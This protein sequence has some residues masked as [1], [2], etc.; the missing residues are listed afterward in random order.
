MVFITR[1]PTHLNDGSPV[2][3]T[4][5][6]AVLKRVWTTF[7]GYTLEGP[8]EGAWVDDS[9]KLYSETS[10][11]LEVFCDRERLHEAKALVIEIGRELGQLA[12]YFEVRHCDGVE[13]ID[14][15]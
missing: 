2:T 13:L 11:R 12:M 14:C 8:A 7:G 3:K 1:I 9:G 15:R 10:Y 6:D 4:A 5:M